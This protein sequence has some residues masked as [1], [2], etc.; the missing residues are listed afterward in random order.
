MISTV[1][2]PHLSS[3][4]S[5]NRK[6]RRLPDSIKFVSNSAISTTDHSNSPP[7]EKMDSCR[8]GTYFTNFY[9]LLRMESPVV[10]PLLLR[11][12]V[13][14][15]ESGP[16]KV[17]VLLRVAGPL[18]DSGSSWLTI[19]QRRKQVNLLDPSMLSGNSSVGGTRSRSTTA[20][21]LAPKMFSFDNIFSP[22]SS[23]SEICSASLVDLI[24]SV[25]NGQDA[26]LISFGPAKLGKTYSVV[27]CDSSVT[28]AGLIPTAIS[29]LFRLVNDEKEK[30]GAKF[31]IRV[32]AVEVSGVHE[33]V[34]DLLAGMAEEARKQ[35]R[36]QPCPTFLCD[37]PR[38]SSPLLNPNELQASNPEVA[39]QLLD[40]CL[41]RR[42]ESGSSAGSHL[43]FTLH[44]YQFRKDKDGVGGGVS[45]GRNRLQLIDLSSQA[46]EMPLS[47]LGNVIL[48]LIN[49]QKHVVSCKESKIT[50]L[51]KDALNNVASQIALLCHVSCAP[52]KYP[53]TLSVIQMA[54]RVH[55]MRRKRIRTGVG[56]GSADSHR[57]FSSSTSSEP[58]SSEVSSAT[59]V[60]FCGAR[61]GLQGDSPRIPPSNRIQTNPNLKL[62]RASVATSPLASPKM[63]PHS[64]L[65]LTPG[66][67]VKTPLVPIKM[68]TDVIEP[69]V[70]PRPAPKPEVIVPK[71]KK[72]K[73]ANTEPTSVEA[74]TSVIN[75]SKTMPE[76]RPI[77]LK[78]TKQTQAR[79]VPVGYPWAG[80]VDGIDTVKRDMIQKW[81]ELQSPEEE[82]PE[83]LCTNFKI[84]QSTELMI[85]EEPVMAVDTCDAAQ[86]VSQLEILHETHDICTDTPEPS[87]HQISNSR[88]YG[89]SQ[90]DLEDL[91]ALDTLA[92]HLSSQLDLLSVELA[93][94]F[95]DEREVPQSPPVNIPQPMRPLQ[96]VPLPL[97]STVSFEDVWQP[98]KPTTPS[99]PVHASQ[100]NSL[101]KKSAPAPP[102]RSS[103]VPRQSID[104]LSPIK[105]NTTR[106]KPRTGKLTSK[107][108]ASPSK[109]SVTYIAPSP[110]LSHDSGHDSGSSLALRNPKQIPSISNQPGNSKRSP[111]QSSSSGHGSDEHSTVSSSAPSHKTSA[112]HA[113]T[114]VTSM[115]SL[116]RETVQL[117]AVSPETDLSS[118][119]NPT[120]RLDHKS[121]H[122]H[123]MED[124]SK[125]TTRPK[126]WT[127]LPCFGGN[128]I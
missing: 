78:M 69:V 70:H 42:R 30:T 96:V 112:L 85:V 47:G 104:G 103:S 35:A 32:S 27:G 125:L 95:T 87:L 107:V 5:C 66:S 113:A 89:I 51:L 109:A 67:P 127:R 79:R 17:K 62:I 63:V 11:N 106:S 86:Q 58:S 68:A 128:E 18:E 97:P 111:S 13:R 44:L 119:R 115:T 117:M 88:D 54:S 15:P 24:H 74:Q 21:P 28:H 12:P 120:A 49:G 10:P 39:G 122:S 33:T 8:N 46:G 16:G 53:E 43:F 20:L 102:T 80:G 6:K 40:A 114:T 55:R 126:L 61:T 121:T 64:L 7:D 73:E 4:S 50:Q 99:T 84:S 60:I 1:S 65:T 105:F 118:V 59:T 92:S 82:S 23:Q 76:I 93:E 110:D 91:D 34:T 81:V 29:W 25:V 14:K 124:F 94:S 123:E 26:C 45:G 116:Q 108:V 101:R 37:D 57:M 38:Y 41:K 72:T 100:N 83:A 90:Q 36:D 77:S 71:V 31:T 56:Y 2:S 75:K 52:S 19:D 3:A 22:D 9:R 98:Y 48:A